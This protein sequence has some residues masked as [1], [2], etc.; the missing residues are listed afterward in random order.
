MR[1]FAI[2]VCLLCLCISATAAE[3][4]HEETM[5]RTA[6]AKFAYAVQQGAV[7]RLAL[8]AR[9]GKTPKEYAKM[10]SA[11]RLA[12][13]QI[14]FTLSDFTIGDMRDI[15]NSRISD[16]VTQPDREVIVAS[17]TDMT[18]SEFSLNTKWGWLD[19]TWQEAPAPPPPSGANMT[20]AEA[21]PLIGEKLPEDLAWQR[22][23]AYT[24]TVNFQGKDRGPYRA[25]FIFGHDTK[26]NALLEPH[27]LT[28][29]NTGLINAL[30]LTLYPEP[31]LLGTLRTYSVTAKWLKD[32][33]MPDAACSIGRPDL[34]CDLVKLKCGP[35]RTD[36]ATRLSQ[37]LP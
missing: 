37:P 27:D 30:H 18:Y 2:T 20:F 3:M 13:A 11:E 36:L 10:T 29:D 33:Q 32:S 4:T 6:Y 8:E 31:L 24:V 26:G 9:S 17:A 15:V 1:H 23:A 35:G 28:T 22:Y 5:V 7:S 21:F 25:L 14:T 34:C 19:A 16:Y 12:D